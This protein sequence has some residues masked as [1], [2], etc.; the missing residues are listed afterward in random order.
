[1][2]LNAKS[3]EALTA[4]RD[5]CADMVRDGSVTTEQMREFH[6]Q[7]ANVVL[8][9]ASRKRSRDA[10]PRDPNK[11][12]QILNP[13][14]MYNRHVVNNKPDDESLAAARQRGSAEWKQ[15]SSPDATEEQKKVR[16]QFVA[17]HAEHLKAYAAEMA[18]YEAKRSA[19]ASAGGASASAD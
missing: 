13:G 11:P 10:A 1:M 8:G 9:T 7:Y 5:L 15:M 18:D 17:E 2:P 14:M 3:S 6:R 19:Q 12:K 4:L 16:A